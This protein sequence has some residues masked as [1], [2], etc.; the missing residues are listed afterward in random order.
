MKKPVNVPCF[1]PLEH[2]KRKGQKGNKQTNLEGKRNPKFLYN[3]GSGLHLIR[4][5]LFLI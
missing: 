4:F 3:T 1:F 2:N 5:N